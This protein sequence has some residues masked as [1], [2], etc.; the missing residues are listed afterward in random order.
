MV[1]VVIVLSVSPGVPSVL[2]LP[3]SDK[4]EHVA[5][6]MTLMFWFCQLHREARRQF[7]LGV[8][9][10]ALGVGLELI[11]GL[12][13]FR[14]A[15]LADALADGCGILMGW[16]VV[17]TRLGNVLPYLDGRLLRLMRTSKSRH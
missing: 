4:L 2:D 10:F 11:Q 14:T 7:G 15:E 13:V 3:A 17:K 9:L 12:L 1:A 6:Y 5:A 8:G 16:G